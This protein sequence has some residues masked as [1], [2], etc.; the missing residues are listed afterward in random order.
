[1]S[2]A[3]AGSNYTI[4]KGDTL[5]DI[6]AQVYGSGQQYTIIWDANKTTLRSGDPN[7]IYPGE[8]LWIPPKPN[9][10]GSYEGWR[11]R[12]T[13]SGGGP[14]Y[15]DG[16]FTLL[17]D[18]QEVDVTEASFLSTL[19]TPADGW[20]ANIR[21]DS[22]DNRLR[23]LIKPYGY[24]DSQI[25]I[26]K[27]DMGKMK[28]YD[29][30][31]NW[32]NTSS[33]ASLAGFSPTA[34]ILDCVSEPSF[35]AKNIFLKDWITKLV[36]P[37]GIS[38]TYKPKDKKIRKI[39]IDKSQT[40]GGHIDKWVKQRG[41]VW[42]N[43]RDGNIIIFDVEE[44]TEISGTFSEDE[45]TNLEGGSISFLGRKR[46]K[47]VL[48]Y[49]SKPRKHN[50]FTHLFAFLKSNRVSAVVVDA[51]DDS[52]IEEAV[53]KLAKESINNALSISIPTREWY[54][55]FGELWEVGQYVTV[56]SPKMF[57]D[58][59]MTL[60]IKAVEYTISGTSRKCNLT[61]CPPSLYIQGEV[62]DPWNLA[63]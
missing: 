8:Q 51:T 1:M 55:D 54:N 35:K 11:L 31:M 20:K 47:K 13:G 63:Q 32:D 16:K 62:E 15:P 34:D 48:G 49:S 53:T 39:K 26:G 42:A 57:L 29:V 25:F 56:H 18:G 5:W 50:S 36:A 61:V 38:V 3:V 27:H 28:L 4:V 43:D 6:A 22:K 59:K 7:R 60:L 45:G 24:Q 46:F 2:S 21:F 23:E 12:Q 9:T 41:H 14:Q 19:D 10:A 37:Y 58:R 17:L 40:I 33:K 52:D 30:T 44:P